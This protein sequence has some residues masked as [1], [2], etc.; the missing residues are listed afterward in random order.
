MGYYNQNYEGSAFSYTQIDTMVKH[1]QA[2][3][4]RV[5]LIIHQRHF[6]DRVV[7]ESARGIVRRWREGGFLYSCAH[8]NNDDWYWLYAAAWCGSHV[9]VVTNDQCR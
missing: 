9:L 3:G 1:F 7:P 4:K 8:K 2:E 5:L 6:G